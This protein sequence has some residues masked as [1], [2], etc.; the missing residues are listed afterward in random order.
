MPKLEF[1]SG[2]R[3]A[4]SAPVID[5]DRVELAR[6][7][8]HDPG[9]TTRDRVAGSLIMLF[10]QP[11][12]H[13]ARLTVQDITIDQNAVAIRLGT[14]PITVPEPLAGH[15]RSLVDDRSCRAT[16][17]LEEHRWLFPGNV[18]GR[19]IDEQVL[20]RRLKRIGVNCAA[21]RRGALLQLAG[22]MPAAL[23]A[24]LLGVHIATA[25][26]W[27]QIA[28]RPWGDYPALRNP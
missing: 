6:R 3:D 5:Q 18:A 21:A 14:S 22:Q 24:D 15:L 11:V 9:I 8:L 4:L 2:R 20:S 13:V 17:R 1:P 16:A 19:A 23:L 7:L 10:A 27:A 25:T 26:Q 12:S 28:G